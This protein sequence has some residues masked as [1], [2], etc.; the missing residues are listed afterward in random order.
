MPIARDVE[1]ASDHLKVLKPNAAVNEK[2]SQEEFD[3]NAQQVEAI[4][5]LATRVRCQRME[6]RT[7][8]AMIDQS[9]P[10]YLSV[11]F[12]FIFTYQAGMPDMPSFAK[13]PRY[14]RQDPA[15]R[16]ETGDWVRV[17]SRRVEASV[18]RDWTFGFV[19]WNYLFRSSV[20]LARSIYAYEREN[21]KDT[22]AS[23]TPAPLE[24]GAI[25]IAQGLWKQYTDVSGRKQAVGG[26]MTKVRYVDG[27]SESAQ[28]LFKNIEH[29][30]RKLPATQETRR[31]MRFQTQAFRIKYGTS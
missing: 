11:A 22:L 15:P 3:V 31:I 5:N 7:G 21:G 9:V 30:S 27:L 20:N 29:A 13:Q 19:T 28:L 26:D 17:M 24:K 12:S 6:A 16:I 8:N 18:S 2:S 25:E 4:Q 1:E 14:R 23:C 10:W